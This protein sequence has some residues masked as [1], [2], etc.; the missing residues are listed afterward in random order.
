M[1]FRST[2][3]EPVRFNI[4]L[5]DDE[6][7]IVQP[8]LTGVRGVDSATLLLR[9]RATGDDLFPAFRQAFHWLWDRSIP[10]C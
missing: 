6:I 3:E 10:S 8:Y 4:V 7:G 1:L 5:I 9:S 2:Y